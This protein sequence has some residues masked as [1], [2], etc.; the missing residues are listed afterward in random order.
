MAGVKLNFL[1]VCENASIS[2]EGK[3]SV[4]GIF[5]QIKF[6]RL[7][8]VYP[9][10]FVVVGLIGNKNTYSEEIQ[11]ISPDEE[12]VASVKN[13]DVEIREDGGSAN[14][15]ASFAGFVFAKQGKYSIKVLV[16]GTPKD[17]ITIEIASK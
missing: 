6:D 1:H 15:I 10:F 16:D 9:I 3:L 12:L 5:N 14:F 7:P 13:D 4:I 8:A 2:R 17:E 11:I